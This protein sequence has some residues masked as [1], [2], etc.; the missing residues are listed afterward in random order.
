MYK[1]L[2]MLP[3]LCSQHCV[4]SR[5]SFMPIMY[6]YNATLNPGPENTIKMPYKNERSEDESKKQS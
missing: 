6:T 4:P 1:V 3:D 5:L 2:N